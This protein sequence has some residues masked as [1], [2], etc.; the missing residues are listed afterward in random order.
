MDFRTEPN[1]R[2]EKNHVCTQR[3]EEEEATIKNT[4]ISCQA[5]S[6]SEEW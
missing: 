1:R 5:N 2:K 3:N 4:V 6:E